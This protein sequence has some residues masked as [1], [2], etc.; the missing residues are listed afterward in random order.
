MVIIALGLIA[1]VGIGFTLWHQSGR[2]IEPSGKSESYV[3]RPAGT[4]TFNKHIAPILHVECATCH[5]PGQAGPFNLITY[6]DASKRAK[7][8]G[9]VTQSRFMPPWLPEHGLEPLADE[10]RLTAEQLGLIQQWVADGAPE[11]IASDLPPSPQWADGWQLGPPDLVVTMPATYTL[12]A[13]GKD[14]YRNFIIPIPVSSNRYVR[15]VEF[16]ADTKAIH[17]AFIRMD[18]TRQSRKLETKESQPGFG[19]ME[20]PVGVEDMGGHFMSWQPGRG[21]TRIPDGLAFTLPA[22]ADF[23]L[24]FHMQPTGKPEPIRSSIALYF[25]DQAPTN[26]PMKISLSSFDIDIPAN[27]TDF[28]IQ[29]SYELPVD[30]DL[31]AVLPHTHYLGKRLEGFATLPDGTRKDLLLIKDW[32]FNWQSDYRFAQAVPL[33]KGTRLSMRYTFDNTTN[34]VRNPNHPPLRVKYGLQSSDEMGELWFQ[35]LTRNKT[36]F[37]KLEDDYTVRALKEVIAFNTYLLQ[38]NPNNARAHNQMAK[39]LLYQRKPAEGIAHLQ[40]ALRIQPDN[41][42]AHYHL[43]VLAMDRQNF[44][45]AEAEFEAT[46]RSNPEHFKARNNLGLVCLRQNRMDEAE[47]HFN[48]VLRL[49]PGDTIAE[50]NLRIVARSKAG[51]K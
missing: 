1:M 3:P 16:R 41:D 42:E 50:G 34:N 51:K 29:D 24:Q 43:G 35:V 36:D 26:R 12:P 46:L 4:V 37:T 13:D 44:A 9:E 11:G 32:D 39:A 7:Q 2:V 40:A 6:A 48:E 28:T 38:Q 15:A 33:P 27:S 14:I 21:P 19:G 31:L 49:N 10:R 25:T 8:I 45:V 22:G 5:R 17:H 20:T 30:V 18:R 47:A 23:V